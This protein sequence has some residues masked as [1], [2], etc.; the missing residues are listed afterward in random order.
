MS[1]PTPTQ[2]PALRLG[3]FYTHRWRRA[4]VTA[5]LPALQPGPESRASHSAKHTM[6]TAPV[7]SAP[8]LAPHLLEAR[9]SSPLGQQRTSQTFAALAE[10]FL[11]QSATQCTAA[12]QI[13]P[14]HSHAAPQLAPASASA[15]LWQPRQQGLSASVPSHTALPL[16]DQVG[17]GSALSHTPLTPCL[18]LLQPCS[19]H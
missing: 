4:I 5:R 11:S 13:A 16:Q 14:L 12:L 8:Q 15:L 9:R 3:T 10:Q 19:A 7:C 17:R 18:L 1:L 6:A 2:L